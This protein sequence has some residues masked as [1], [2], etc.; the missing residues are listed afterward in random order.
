[1]PHFQCNNRLIS[2]ALFDS[3]HQYFTRNQ[4]GVVVHNLSQQRPPSLILG[5]EIHRGLANTESKWCRFDLFS[6]TDVL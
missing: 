6:H 5:V 3:A 2:E 1:M 4:I